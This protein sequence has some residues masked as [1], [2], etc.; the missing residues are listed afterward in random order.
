MTDSV[1]ETIYQAIAS[2]R[3]IDPAHTHQPAQPGIEHVGGSAGLSLLH[4]TRP[5]G[6]HAQ[7]RD[8]GRGNRSSRTRRRLVNNYRR[9]RTPLSID[10]WSRSAA[11]S[12]TSTGIESTAAT[13]S[14]SMTQQSGGWRRRTGRKPSSIGATWK[15]CFSPMIL[16]IA[17]SGLRYRHLHSL[18]AH[19]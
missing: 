13:G 12:L 8:R 3:L 18:S 11:S 10:G 4:G 17:L 19:R 9:S 5:F 7:G 1:R 15:R 6:R 14:R 2:I 16:M